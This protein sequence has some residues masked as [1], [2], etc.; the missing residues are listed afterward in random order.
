LTV[1]G[2]KGGFDD[3]SQFEITTE[4]NVIIFSMKAI[5]TGIL[6]TVSTEAHP[7]PIK[8]ES[9]VGFFKWEMAVRIPSENKNIPL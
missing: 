8:L 2:V 4:G 1:I 6:M 7:D 9:E 5:V 3:E